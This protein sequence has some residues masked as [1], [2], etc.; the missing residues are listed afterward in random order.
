MRAVSRSDDRRDALSRWNLRMT[1]SSNDH[2]PKTSES[3]G[4]TE[5]GWRPNGTPSPADETQPAAASDQQIADELNRQGFTTRRG[6]AW[7]HQYVA[8][9]AA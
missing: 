2:T 7:R 3:I 1:D 5:A 8:G 4:S 6:T 9:L